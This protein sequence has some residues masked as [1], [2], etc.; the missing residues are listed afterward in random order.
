[1]RIA[2]IN[3]PNINMLGIREPSEYGTATFVDLENMC[4]KWAKDLKMDVTCFQSNSE[5]AII[6]KIQTL[7][8][9]TEAIIINAGAY[10]HTSIGIRDALLAV[11]IPIYEVH[12][13]NILARES[14]RHHTYISDIAVAVLCGF[15]INGYKYALQQI[16]DT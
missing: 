11:N 10:S 15:G 2:I 1:M 7:H 4:M 5:G 3:G 8:G 6:D 16:A 9:N 12:I 13:S 14:F